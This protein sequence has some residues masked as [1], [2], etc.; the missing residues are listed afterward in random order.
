MAGGVKIIMNQSNSRS[1]EEGA[2]DEGF[3]Y[4]V[5]GRGGFLLSEP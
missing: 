3:V 1:E 4:K 2:S 5:P